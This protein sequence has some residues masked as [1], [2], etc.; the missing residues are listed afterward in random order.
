MATFPTKEND[1]IALAEAMIAGL[2][3]NPGVFPNPPVAVG[4]LANS[5]TLVKQRITSIDAIKGNLTAEYQLKE[6]QL[7]GGLTPEMKQV[8]AW[9]EAITDDDP[10]KLQLIGWDG[11]KAQSP[12]IPPG[13][14]RY[15]EAKF[16]GAGTVVFDWKA[17]VAND[18]GILKSYCIEWRELPDGDWAECGSTTDREKTLLNQPRG[19]ELEYRVCGLNSAGQGAPSNTVSLVL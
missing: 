10:A 17:P 8:L 5:V 6:Q 1:I 12:T 13:Q 19:K 9:A 18:G 2:S 16:Q 7:E 14:P 15:F 4:V 11:R 3:A